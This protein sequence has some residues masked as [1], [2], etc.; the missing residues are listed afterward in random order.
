MCFF[1]G[2]MGLLHDFNLQEAKKGCD[3]VMGWKDY[4]DDD[5]LTH[6]CIINVH[7]AS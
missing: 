1:Q 5:I 4:Q 3:F 7:C 6:L 2:L